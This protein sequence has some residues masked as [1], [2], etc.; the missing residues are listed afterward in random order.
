LIA[1]PVIMPQKSITDA[2]EALHRIILAE[3]GAAKFS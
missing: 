3:P 1:I 2:A